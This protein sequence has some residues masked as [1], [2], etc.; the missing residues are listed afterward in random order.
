MVTNTKI[1]LLQ[2]QNNFISCYFVLWWPSK[3]SSESVIYIY[4]Y[5]SCNFQLCVVVS[6]RW[7]LMDVNAKVA[8]TCCQGPTKPDNRLTVAVLYVQMFF[9]S[10]ILCIW[11]TSPSVVLVFI[12]GISVWLTEILKMDLK[13]KDN[14]LYNWFCIWEKQC[15]YFSK[16]EI[17]SFCMDKNYKNINKCSKKIQHI[18]ELF[19]KFCLDQSYAIL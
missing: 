19:W 13:T 14:V 17:M 9:G 5:T 4:I 1:S 10:V 2:F 3:L 7:R 18:R 16:E 6:K 8:V 15:R 12:L 11:Y